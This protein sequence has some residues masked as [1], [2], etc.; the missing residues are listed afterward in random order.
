MY[1]RL[2]SLWVYYIL[3]L[4]VKYASVIAD[5]TAF[6]RTI[7]K[8]IIDRKLIFTDVN[9]TGKCTLHSFGL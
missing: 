1:V 9:L 2:H 4:C 8:S 3:S 7:N 6:S 5:G